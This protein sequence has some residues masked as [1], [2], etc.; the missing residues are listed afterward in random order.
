MSLTKNGPHTVTIFVEEEGTDYEG[1][2]YKKPSATGVRV[3]NCWMQPLAST[4]GAFA[5]RKVDTGQDV[6]S[7]FKLICYSARA[8]LGWW[9]RIE[10]FDPITQTL[11][12]F[13]VLGGPMP[14][15][16]SAATNH[17]SCTLQEMR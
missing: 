13:A 17:L 1:N 16:F 14:R 11:R 3:N 2:P 6:T 7:A 10:W 4:R 15:D 9:S 5:A 12:K 8:P